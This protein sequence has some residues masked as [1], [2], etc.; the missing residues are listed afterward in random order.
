MVAD[1]SALIKALEPLG[2]IPR[3]SEF[4]C[5]LP[6]TLHVVKPL[7]DR[8]IPECVYVVHSVFPTRVD[9]ELPPIAEVEESLAGFAPPFPS[10]WYQG[11]MNPSV[12]RQQAVAVLSAFRDA[13]DL[14]HFA[15][16][17]LKPA[18]AT[19]P[20][21]LS[22]V[23]AVRAVDRISRALFPSNFRVVGGLWRHEREE[24]GFCFVA[25][26]TPNRTRTLLT[27]TIF[28]ATC[29]DIDRAKASPEAARRI[30]SSRKWTLRQNGDP[31]FLPLCYEDGDTESVAR[32][33]LLRYVE[34]RKPNATVVSD[35]V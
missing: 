12:V 3:R 27:V 30:F 22:A 6:E 24:G 34:S 28:A 32:E 33:H 26:L 7:K 13:A 17:S 1:R 11:K 23:D 4:R 16:N 14:A 10:G 21:T 20:R 29:G 5:E 25:D 35:E 18:E 8:R 9:D 19:A 15:S 31:I 2:F